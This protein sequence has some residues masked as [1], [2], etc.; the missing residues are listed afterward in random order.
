MQSKHFIVSIGILSIVHLF[1]GCGTTDTAASATD[2]TATPKP[3]KVT[4]KYTGMEK[5][6][7][8]EDFAAHIQMHA[9]IAQ[10]SLDIEIDTKENV[11]T[12]DMAHMQVYIDIDDNPITGLRMGEGIY[13]INGAEYMIED[14]HLF[15][16]LSSNTWEWEYV[17]DVTNRDEGL[18]SPQPTQYRK[19]ISID[20]TLFDVSK[21][22]NMISI[23]IEP[24]DEN[25]EDTNNYVPTRRLAVKKPFLPVERVGNIPGYI[26]PMPDTYQWEHTWKTKF[27]DII[28]KEAYALSS[29]GASFG[30]GAHYKPYAVVI[31]SI[32]LENKQNPVLLDQIEVGRELK[33]VDMYTDPENPYIYVVSRE[34]AMDSIPY[35][36]SYM[37][38]IDR[39][40]P[41]SLKNRGVIR[42]YNGVVTEVSISKKENILRIESRLGVV[43]I[44]ISNPNQP[45][46]I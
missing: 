24:I 3:H 18:L 9:K 7:N 34:P 39:S 6:L 30:P 28:G 21:L 45:V 42:L 15:K 32:N 26:V 35:P 37:T 2:N 22:K 11:I 16:S 33:P 1:N 44:D 27:I 25:W 13:S 12:Y 36:K 10:N 8:Y 31:S 4:R 19:F 20:F 5:P 29:H 43:E 46:K 38:I 14:N 40:D 41:T 17:A 23:S